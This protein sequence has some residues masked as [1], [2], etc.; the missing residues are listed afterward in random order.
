MAFASHEDI[1]AQWRPL[2]EPEQLRA[3]GLLAVAARL[4]RRHVTIADD[5]TELLAVAKQ[6]SIE[7]VTATLANG[8]RQA[9]AAGAV[10]TATLEAAS[11]SVEYSDSAGSWVLTFTPEL[12]ELFGLTTH[13]EPAYYFG[14]CPQ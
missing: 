8:A 14:D 3:T 12:R 4:I 13:P 11:Y 2:T 10:T 5:D 1:A 9:P 7:M 6:A